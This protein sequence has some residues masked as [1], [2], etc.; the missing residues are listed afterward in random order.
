MEK[1][2]EMDQAHFYLFEKHKRKSNS[3][4]FIFSLQVLLLP[5]TD[6]ATL[7]LGIDQ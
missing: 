6:L 1:F 2:I 7:Y 4:F 3:F 5:L